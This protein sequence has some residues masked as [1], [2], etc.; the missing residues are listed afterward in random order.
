MFLGY[1]KEY[2]VIRSKFVYCFLQHTSWHIMQ[3]GELR[4]DIHLAPN[5]LQIKQASFCS[6]GRRTVQLL[7]SETRS[8]YLCLTRLIDFSSPTITCFP[9]WEIPVPWTL[10][11]SAAF[12]RCIM[13]NGVRPRYVQEHKCP[14]GGLVCSKRNMY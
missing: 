2:F 14:N 5:Y 1:C 10:T 3:S 13:V 7:W 11:F 8:S 4:S 12:E 9:H 6:A